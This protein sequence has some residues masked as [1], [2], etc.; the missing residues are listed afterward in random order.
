MIIERD[1]GNDLGIPGNPIEGRFLVHHI[2]PITP[3]NC[4]DPDIVY[5]PDNL[6]LCSY[7]THN[8][9]HYRK[10]EQEPIFER[11]ENDYYKGVKELDIAGTIKENSKYRF[12]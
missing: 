6:I 11:K 10:A 7:D 5:N 3:D 2:I 1:G 4:E 12:K 8:K 9:I